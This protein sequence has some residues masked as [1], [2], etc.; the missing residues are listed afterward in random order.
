MRTFIAIDFD[1]QIKRQLSALQVKLKPRCGS[2]K[3]VDP[4]QMHLTLKFLGEIKES[5]VATIRQALDELAAQCRPINVVVEELGTF[6][7]RGAVKVLWV[8]IKDAGGEL[9]KC[10]A[11]CEDLI[12]PL[13]F[14]RENRPFSPHLTLARTRDDSNS[15]QIRTALQ[16][17]PPFQAG[18]QTISGVTFYQSTLTPRGPIY[19]AMSRHQFAA[20]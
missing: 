4:R 13:G 11:R 3:W 20:K 9:A 5:Q 12:E 18:S 8:G 2:L 19:D 17:E 7:P 10:Q 14:P 1:E 16:Q 6:P 15:N